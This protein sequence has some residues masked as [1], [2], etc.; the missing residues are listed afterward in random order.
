MIVD[1]SPKPRVKRKLRD[2]T[3]R[4]HQLLSE[5]EVVSNMQEIGD[6]RK[7]TVAKLR[8]AVS[9][10]PNLPME[11]Q[12]D[13]VTRMVIY[14]ASL[15]FPERLIA[16]ELQ[17]KPKQ[18]H[19]ILSSRSVQ[20]ELNRVNKSLIDSDITKVFQK[21][22]PE[23]IMTTYKLMSDEEEKGA[24]RLDAAKH[25][26]DRALG[27]PKETMENKTTLVSQVFDIINKNKSEIKE[28][29]PFEAEFEEIASK[30]ED[31]LEG[32]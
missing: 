17:I 21:I 30:E 8:A 32:L 22:L 2:S 11:E 27:K 7:K 20:A 19:L 14:Y 15:G 16:K 9:E 3:H 28:E 6:R 25:F 31:P 26:M 24:T 13:Q 18:V 29:L 4:K 23:A 12:G 10:I 1:E 5:G